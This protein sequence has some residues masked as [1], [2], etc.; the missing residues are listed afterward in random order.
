MTPGN[1]AD[2][3]KHSKRQ[4]A[5]ESGLPDGFNSLDISPLRRS[6][7]VYE[8]RTVNSAADLTAESTEAEIVIP[9]K[10]LRKSKPEYIDSEVELFKT[11]PEKPRLIFSAIKPSVETCEKLLPSQKLSSNSESGPKAKGKK[12]KNKKITSPVSSGLSKESS[13]GMRPPSSELQEDPSEK[14]P[15][16]KDK[17][18]QNKFLQITITNNQK[19]RI[20]QVVKEIVRGTTPKYLPEVLNN[21]IQAI[22]KSSTTLTDADLRKIRVLYNMLKTATQKQKEQEEKELQEK[23]EQDNIEKENG[24]N[25]KKKI[26]PV[27]DTKENQVKGEQLRRMKGPKRYVVFVGN[28]PVNITKEEILTHF[29][30]LREHIKDVRIPP[31]KEDKKS[32][33]AYVEFNTE[34]SYEMALSKHHSML[35][36]K[37]IN[38]LYTVQ[39]GSKISKADAKGKAAKLVAMGK[40]GQLI[41]SVALT[42]KRSH[43]RAKMRQARKAAED[44]EN[45]KRIR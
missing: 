5:P 4:R 38:V 31:T 28:L 17:N 23:I 33:I 22:L 1:S 26:K 8:H 15:I 24:E 43:R 29:S 27:G 2:M 37:R 19:G 7:Y 12:N 14:Y 41:G 20:R 30:D 6:D 39:K 3:K 36:N 18:L 32:S 25:V 9:R 11:T 45:A 35:S 40:K 42:K 34:P 13:K 10:R 44:A 21:R 16:L